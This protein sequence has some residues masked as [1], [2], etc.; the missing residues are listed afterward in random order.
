[1]LAYFASRRRPTT[2]ITVPKRTSCWESAHCRT[3]EAFHRI[4]SRSNIK[5]KEIFGFFSS[6]GLA[7]LAFD[8][9]LGIYAGEVT[10]DGLERHVELVGN[11]VVGVALD[12]EPQPSHERPGSERRRAIAS[13]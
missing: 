2:F 7:Q 5:S 12:S 4:D 6:E 13:G 10:L 11:L 9:E 1:M 3:P 8:P